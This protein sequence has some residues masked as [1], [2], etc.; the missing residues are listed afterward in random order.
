MRAQISTNGNVTE[1]IYFS[2]CTS[3]VL[4][5]LIALATNC[6]YLLVLL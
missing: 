6:T 3:I 1:Y 2:A 4:N 5:I